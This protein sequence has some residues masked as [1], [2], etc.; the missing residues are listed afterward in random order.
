MRAVHRLQVLMLVAWLNGVANADV[1]ERRGGEP[2]IQGKVVKVDEAGV[3]IDR[4]V[5][6]T[7]FVRWDRVRRVESTQYAREIA[8]FQELADQLWRARTR[9]ERGDTAMAEPIL[10]RLFERYNGQKN[11]TALVVAEGLLRCRL[12]RG[13]ND[14]ALEP[15]LETARLRRSVPGASTVYTRLP[16]LFHEGTNL[17]VLLPPA[18]VNSSSLIRI[19]RELAAYDARGDVVVAAQAVLYRQAIRQQLGVGPLQDDRALAADHP[20]VIVLKEFVN[21]GS[22]DEA[23]RSAAREAMLA[24]LAT[25]EPWQQA[26]AHYAIGLSLMAETGEGRKQT[27]LVHLAHLPARF[28]NDQR[29]LAGLALA[30]MAESFDASGDQA[31]ATALRGELQKNYPNHPAIAS[32]RAKPAAPNRNTT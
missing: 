19:E 6:E 2:E 3:T 22:G 5:A 27:G 8:E 16:A 10:E 14:E 26:W 7:E 29:F 13:A 31:S 12:A 20:G 1:L 28:A 25:V 15:A 23:Q 11:E 18:F 24:R 17:C 30:K 32:S 21:L 4:G 9:I